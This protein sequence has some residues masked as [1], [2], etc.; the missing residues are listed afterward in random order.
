MET[1]KSKSENL[2]KVKVKTLRKLKLKRGI[3]V[4]CTSQTEQLRTD[5]SE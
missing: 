3:K 2:R 1:L 4:K 5:E